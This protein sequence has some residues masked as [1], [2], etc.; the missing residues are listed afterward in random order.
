MNQNSLKT[1]W[2]WL[3]RYSPEL[4]IFMLAL[5]PVFYTWGRLSIGGD[6][7]IP[8]NSEGLEKYLYQWIEMKNGQ[9]FA[10]NYYVFYIMY[11]VAELFTG[12]IL[13]ISAALLFFL[14]LIAG[15]GIYKLAQ[16]FS[17]KAQRLELLVPIV[18]YLLSP[19]LLN[20]YHYIFVYAFT[21][22]FIYFI[23]RIVKEKNVTIGTA[24]WLNVILAF[25]SLDLPN[26]KYL[27]H[28]FLIS[29][30]IF[31][32]NWSLQ[33]ITGVELRKVLIK[34]SLAFV[35]SA[36]LFLPL[37]NFTLN[38][39][40]IDYGVKVK[41]GY[42]DI[43]K[44]MNFGVDTMDKILK[45]HQ[46]SIFLNHLDV[47]SYNSSALILILSYFF[48]FAIFA[49]LLIIHSERNVDK[50]DEI[51]VWLLLVIYLFF[52]AGPNKPFG[53][54]YE[55]FVA[56]VPLLAFLRTTAGAV[57]FLS[58]FYALLLFFFVEQIPKRR[59]FFSSLILLVTIYVGYPYWNGEYYKNFNG[60]NQYT[61]IQQR[62]FH[63]PN[64]YY[65]VRE[66]IDYQKM[67][68]R[69]FYPNSDLT[70]LNTQWGF[71]GP[72]IY[73]FLYTNY[74]LG[75]DKVLGSLSNHAVGFIFEDSS[76]MNKIVYYVKNTAP[77]FQEGFLSIQYVDRNE[78]LPKLYTAESVGTFDDAPLTQILLDNSPIR[79]AER[80][81]SFQNNE[82]NADI[83]KE[84]IFSGANIEYKKINPTQYRVR[85]HGAQGN[86]ALVLS[87]QYHKDWNV[88]L[89]EKK[90][91]YQDRELLLSQLKEYKTLE[92]NEYFQADTEELSRL[93]EEGDVTELGDGQEKNI[94]H[95]KWD[96][97]E[98]KFD[99]IERFS[100]D[101]VSKKFF[102]TVQNDNLAEVGLFE[103][104]F[105]KPLDI[106]NKQLVVNGYG[107]AWIL[108]ID[109]ICQEQ[110]ENCLKNKDETRDLEVIVEFWPQRVS[111]VGIIISGLGLLW[112][113]LLLVKRALKKEKRQK[114][115]H[116][117]SSEN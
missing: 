93:I 79:H 2:R 51:I 75:Y 62:G 39:D 60:I 22:W 59:F 9:Y 83:D 89:V 87:E 24:L 74:N 77:A 23:F 70:Y 53:Q 88:Y 6:V 110:P 111:Y 108:N 90:D 103:T 52:A 4:V 78:F 114:S 84:G 81:V 98:G 11:W 106:R 42:K 19:A 96:D 32:A 58:V 107:N 50:R 37:A 57:F 46:D 94:V 91:F 86:V 116:D 63:I 48:V 34:F 72:I 49:R 17:P 40:P 115:D 117:K 104:W 99:F 64:E 102:N 56:S 100:I 109:A 10:V 66:F 12:N 30:I 71:F 92:K 15:F 105:Q 35:L 5:L 47:F 28:L 82:I 38:Y 101:F 55:H 14:T 113:L 95:K 3:A 76:L 80:K 18:F 33:K 97:Y 8:F 20:A 69:T 45:L 36:Y 13:F 25:C 41:S 7:L 73:N 31:F 43:G 1:F 16:L 29:A 27:F 54:M 67:N 61:N 85:L 68:V 44:M 112:C 21:P 26:P 65:K